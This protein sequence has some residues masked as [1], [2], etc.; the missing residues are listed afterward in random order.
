[1]PG[2]TRS[3]D[4]RMNELEAV[5]TRG[6]RA[7]FEAGQALGEI[8]EKRLYRRTHDTFEEYC[9]ARWDLTDSRARQLIA[10]A[11]TVTL[12]TVGAGPAPASERVA[13]ELVPLRKRPE[14]LQ[15]AW[16]EAVAQDPDGDP[17]AK[18]VRA[19]V[20]QYRDDPPKRDPKLVPCPT[21]GHPVR[22]DKP[23]RGPGLAG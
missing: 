12:V 8:R 21:C 9:R 3:E 6:L 11:E 16:L 1:V 2:L 17:P 19:V 23:L 4:R 14:V 10:A 18:D 7:F 5:I 22:A 15:A 20:D 13:R